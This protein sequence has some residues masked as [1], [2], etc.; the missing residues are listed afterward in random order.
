[1]V[2]LTRTVETDPCPQGTGMNGTICCASLGAAT[3]TGC[4]AAPAKDGVADRLDMLSREVSRC[5]GGANLDY[6]SRNALSQNG[7][8]HV[9]TYIYI[10]IYCVCFQRF[11]RGSSLDAIR[12]QSGSIDRSRKEKTDVKCDDSDHVP[13]G[14][15]YCATFF[16]KRDW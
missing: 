2:G 5:R 15:A 7:Y 12:I 8:G 16:W 9:Y 14:C 11:Q 13:G 6:S 3:G 10:Y 1:M 4:E